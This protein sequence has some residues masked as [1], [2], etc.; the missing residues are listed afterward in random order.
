MNNTKTKLKRLLLDGRLIGIVSIT[1]AVVFIILSITDLLNTAVKES[2]NNTVKAVFVESFLE[3][4]VDEDG[5]ETTMYYPVVEYTNENGEMIRAMS[6]TGK[7][8]NEYRKGDEISIR[9]DEENPTSFE[10]VPF[11]TKYVL[12]IFLMLIGIGIG[13]VG[14]WTL[15]SYMQ[16]KKS[17]IFD[18]N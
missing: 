2:N 4:A 14:V 5:V 18:A 12:P 7:K 9:I 15:R 11:R 16:N 3:E 1:V 6:I 8:F 17:G 10:I 13:G